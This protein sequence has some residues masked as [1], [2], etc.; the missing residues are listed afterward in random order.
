MRSF[1]VTGIFFV[2]IAS[3]GALFAQVHA[4]AASAD[5][6]AVNRII[7]LDPGLSFGRATFLFPSSL[8]SEIPFQDPFMSHPERDPGAAGP[9]IGLAAGPRADLMSPLRLQFAKEK[10]SPFQTALGAV[11]LG[12]VGDLASRHIRKYGLFR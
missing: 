7:L 10:L 8:G 3:G 4:G 11:Q 9:F 6:G 1:V 12:A 5:T 2:F